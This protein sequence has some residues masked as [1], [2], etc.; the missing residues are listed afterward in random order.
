M[1]TGSTATGDVFVVDADCHPADHRG[2]AH[3]SRTARHHGRRRRSGTVSTSVRRMLRRAAAVPGR[4]RASTR[5]RVARSRRSARARWSPCAADLLALTLLRAAGRDGRGRRWSARRSGSA[6]RSASAVRTPGT[7]RRATSSSGRCPAGWSACRSTPRAA[8]RTARVADARAAHPP[9]EGDEQHLHRPGAA[10]GDRGPVRVVSRSGRAARDRRRGCTRLTCSSPRACAPPASRCS[11]TTSSTRSR[12]VSRAG[13]ATSR[14]RR[15][16]RRINLRV[17]DDDTL[18]I[19]LDE[20]TRRRSSRKMCEAFGACR[21]GRAAPPARCHP[22]CT[23]RRAFLTH[24][25]FRAHRSETR[26]CATCAS[27]PTG[28]SRWTAR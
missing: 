17:V 13:P 7:S 16:A 25:V 19:S 10:R 9:R 15:R 28:T 22:S 20:T 26:C 3:A 12:C 27:W 14:T 5:P 6:C 23:G 4:E 8:P 18:G 24:P 21:S 11:T 2:R 1:C